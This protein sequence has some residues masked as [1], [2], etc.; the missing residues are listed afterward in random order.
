MTSREAL[1]TTAVPPT[2]LAESTRRKAKGGRKFRS[3]W[4]SFVGRIMAQLIGATATIVL[5]LIVVDKYRTFDEK[6]H[7]AAGA[8][9]PV[10]RQTTGVP[11]LAVLAVQNY[12]QDPSQ[13]AVANAL[14]EAMV[15]AFAQSPGIRVLSRTSSTAFKDVAR[16]LPSIGKELGA[17]WIVESSIVRDGGRLRLTAQLIDARTD[18]HVFARV[19]DRGTEDLLAMESELAASVAADMR[20]A[21]RAPGI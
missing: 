14:T 13:A 15:A 12:S 7:H 16:S 20:A 11:A 17:D 19:Y 5:G 9:A 2:A 1:D 4:I 21:L 3:V 18:E 8:A 10:A 6:A